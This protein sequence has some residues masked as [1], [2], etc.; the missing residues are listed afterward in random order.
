[1]T[2]VPL[3]GEDGAVA[4][5]YNPA[6][7]KTKRKIAER[8]MLTLREVGERSAAAREVKEFWGQVLKGLEYN[9]YDV[10]FVYMY[11]VSDDVDSDMSSM[12]SGSLA[13][14]PQCVL[15][16]TLGVPMG[17]ASITSP[18]DLKTSEQSWAP[19]LRQAMRQDKPILLSTE[20]GNDVLSRL[21]GGLEFRGFG[22]ACRSAVVCPIHPTT[23]ESVSYLPIIRTL[24]MCFMSDV[25][26]Y[27]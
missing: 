6:F 23:G 11:S 16:G 3:V 9:E 12:H 5:L 27:N 8:R 1:M 24:M 26:V 2:S 10:P 20:D 18:L 19:F 17:H 22:D 14:A 4:G 15:E 7:E 25:E 21:M 13:P